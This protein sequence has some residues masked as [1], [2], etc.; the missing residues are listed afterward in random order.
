MA[1]DLSKKVELEHFWANVPPVKLSNILSH[2]SPELFRYSIDDLNKTGS[3][4]FR[5]I[6]V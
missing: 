6:I 3:S 1:N 2:N 5:L 4:G